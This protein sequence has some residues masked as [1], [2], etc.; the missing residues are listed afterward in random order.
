MKFRKH[1]RHTVYF[2]LQDL[3]TV[4]RGELTGNKIE[5]FEKQFAHFIGT[6]Y[7]V[8]IPSCRFGLYHHL[9]T[10]QLKKNDEV[11]MPAYTFEALPFAVLS[12]GANVRYVDTEKDGY[13][14]DVHEVM[15][16]INGNTRAVVISHLYGKACDINE[17]QRI[18]STKNISLIEDCAHACGTDLN[19]KKVGSIGK[20]GL[21][22]FGVG[23]GLN[24]NGGGMLTTDSEEIYE[25]MKIVVSQLPSQRLHSVVKGALKTYVM[26]LLTR[27]FFFSTITYPLIKTAAVFNENFFDDLVNERVTV[28]SFNKGINSSRAFGNGQ[29]ALGLCKLS[30][31]HSLKEGLSRNARNYDA[32]LPAKVLWENHRHQ[33]DEFPSYYV[34]RHP[35][36][37][38]IRLELLSSGID[39]KSCDMNVCP[40]LTHPEIANE[41]PGAR[42]VRDEIIEIPNNTSLSTEDVNLIISKI[43]SSVARTIA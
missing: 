38:R 22:S 32:F 39:T 40:E 10:L 34:I 37:K 31:L 5:E 17:L 2:S 6:R 23:K 41:F 33:E 1:A 18:C 27:P 30:E 29:A 16:K 4:I 36:R 12:N 20:V 7:A 9:K 28:G 25:K 8:A 42:R 11:I 15:K 3:V 14:V 13:N 24:A 35:Q 43:A 21:F 26:S 19:G